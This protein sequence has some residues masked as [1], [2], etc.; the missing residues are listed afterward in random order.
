MALTLED[1]SDRELLFA[2]EE[3]ADANGTITSHELA[4]GIGLTVSNGLKHPHMNVAIRL[5][6]LK[7]FGVVYRDADTH[8]WGLT[9][10]GSRALHQGL[11]AREEKALTEFNDEALFRAV[12]LMGARMLS[13]RGEFATLAQRQWRYSLAQRKRRSR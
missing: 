8:R 9:P 7:R 12:E 1:F 5:G 13:A 3:H 10:I 6:W 2:L 4:E 11:R